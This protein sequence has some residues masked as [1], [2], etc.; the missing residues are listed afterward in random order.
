[1]ANEREAYDAGNEI[2]VG[3]RQDKL[4]LKNLQRSNDLKTLLEMDEGRRIFWWLLGLGGLYHDD[5]NTNALMMSNMAGMRKVS[6]MLLNELKQA[7][8]KSYIRMQ[9]EALTEENSN[10]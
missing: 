2:H 6:L 7:D 10:A 5:F 4:K 1:M 3:K 9:T 8:P